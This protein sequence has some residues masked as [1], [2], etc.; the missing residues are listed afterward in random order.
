MYERATI[1]IPILQVE[2]KW[3]ATRLT[4]QR[5]PSQWVEELLEVKLFLEEDT[6]ESLLSK[7]WG[8]FI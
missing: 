7:T 8:W 1:I 6:K 2:R 3:D 5:S 4:T